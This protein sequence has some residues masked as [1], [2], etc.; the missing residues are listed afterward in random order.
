MQGSSSTNSSPASAGAAYLS[1]S[2]TP[3]LVAFIAS[4]IFP[5]AV[6]VD[7]LAVLIILNHGP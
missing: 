7:T 3:A 6:A 2:N 1:E 5:L 4:L